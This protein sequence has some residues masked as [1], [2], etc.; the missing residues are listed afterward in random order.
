[1]FALCI[2]VTSIIEDPVVIKDG[3]FSWTKDEEPTLSNL[4]FHVKEGSLVAVVGQVGSGKSS[5][6]AALLGEMVKW[7]GKVNVKV[8]YSYKFSVTTISFI[9]RKVQVSVYLCMWNLLC[10]YFLW[11]KSV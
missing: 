8:I 6:L 2:L 1:M 10:L 9:S 4:N 3:T 7:S 11:S 5:L